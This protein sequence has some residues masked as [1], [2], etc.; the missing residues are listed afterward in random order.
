MAPFLD[1][2]ALRLLR[3]FLINAKVRVKIKNEISDE[4]FTADRGYSQ[5]SNLSTFCF[6]VLMSP[7]HN[8][9]DDSTAFSFSDDDQLVSSDN[10]YNECLAK[11][12]RAADSFARFCNNHN[13]KINNSKTNFIC[14]GNFTK[15]EI[16]KTEIKINGENIENLDQISILGVTLNRK[17]SITPYMADVVKIVENKTNLINNFTKYT[18]KKV[19]SILIKSFIFGKLNHGLAYFPDFSKENYRKIQAKINKLTDIKH[20][21]AIERK[22][23]GYSI[24]NQAILLRRGNLLSTPNLHRLSK[25]NRLNKILMTLNPVW[26]F[27]E[28]IGTFGKNWTKSF[29][30]S[31]NGPIMNIDLK[32]STEKTAPKIWCE[33]FNALPKNLRENVGT[34][35]F[36][37]N[38]KKFYKSR[39]QHQE[40]EEILCEACGQNCANYRLHRNDL[41][42]QKFK[43]TNFRTEKFQKFEL[44]LHLSKSSNDYK[45]HIRAINQ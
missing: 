13:I 12:Q 33:D 9:P 45:D 23:L 39:C 22:H 25:M 34:E 27:L 11:A 10:N 14:I 40:V 44:F 30:N 26:E 17:L 35:I 24:N 16:E 32:Y 18:S 8:L 7:S 20:T 19:V 42:C 2:N 29:I 36:E 37:T 3:S 15:S 41:H 43:V 5:G 4:F 31:R 38:I 21:L 1:K 6:L 28:I